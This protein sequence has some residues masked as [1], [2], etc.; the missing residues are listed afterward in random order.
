MV[1]LF[2]INFFCVGEKIHHVHVDPKSNDK[3]TEEYEKHEHQR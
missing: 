1:L 2:Q 3:N